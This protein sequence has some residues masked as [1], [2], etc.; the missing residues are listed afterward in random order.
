ME[1]STSAHPPA[2]PSHPSLLPSLSP[3]LSVEATPQPLHLLPLQHPHSQ[4]RMGPPQMSSQGV[5]GTIMG[6][7]P[8]HA[9]TQDMM[10]Q[11]KIYSAC[12]SGIPVFEA[13]IR[14]IA[15][16]RRG[17]D[18]WVNAT[19][20]LK[21]AGISKS[22]RTKILEKEVL[23]GIHE[24]VQGGYGKYQGTWV[25]YQRG[26][27]LAV[28]YGVLG[29]L[30]PIFDFDPSQAEYQSLPT[31][32]GM[33]TP[34]NRNMIA[35]PG[36]ARLISPF[37]SHA[38]PPPPPPQ[39]T[40]G[41]PMMGLPPHPSNLAYAQGQP[42]M[43]FQPQG[44]PQ[45]TYVQDRKR[46]MGM[47]M[48]PSRSGGSLVATPLAPGVDLDLNGMGLPPPHN[49]VYLDP[50]GH[51]HPLGDYVVNGSDGSGPPPAKKLRSNGPETAAGNGQGEA[52]DNVE[53]LLEA[54][55][56]DD[57]DDS[58]DELQDA[59]PLPTSM[60]LSTKPLRPK[61]TSQSSKTRTKLLSLFSSEE[62]VD[63]RS[64]FNLD[65]EAEAEFDIDMIID[66]QGHT[67]LHWACALAK[68]SIIQQLIALGADINRG[69]YAGETPL[70]R[71]VLA[72]N[73]SEA[74]TFSS[75]L[76]TGLASS[77]RTLDHAYRTVIHHIALIAGVPNR[78]SSARR[79]MT[80]IL[81]Y[82]ARK[83]QETSGNLS[84]KTLVDVQDVHGDTAL[85]VAARVGNR[86]LVNLLLEAGADKT[87]G[88]KLGLRPVDFGVETE[89]LKVSSGEEVIA[90]LKTETNRPEKQSRDVQKN[91]ATI[92]STISETF[93]NEMTVKQTALNKTQ[94]SVRHTTKALAEK[95]QQVASIQSALTELEQIKTKSENLTKALHA[96]SRIDF[97]GRTNST[98][99]AFQQS[100]FGIGNVAFSAEGGAE[101]AIPERGSES[102]LVNLRR[103]MMW[104]TRVGEM[105]E[106]TIQGL[107]GEGSEKEVRYRKLVA[108]CTKVPVDKVD[109]MLDDLTTAIESDG[110][111][112]DLSR[113]SNFMNRMKEV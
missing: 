11:S 6:I 66:D 8:G 24:K 57:D 20:I 35:P 37:T 75:L 65:A 12:Y 68:A 22:S 3:S 83:Q 85:N 54:E 93:D 29:F 4:S 46:P 39:F 100:A 84:M 9:P 78:A 55:E 60:R 28:Q 36:S 73:H 105:L 77:I 97:T 64:L 90:L 110:Q 40:N 26:H 21:V 112:I 67:A 104:E 30:A 51:P 102:A 14:G 79:Y 38:I 5:F 31:T 108:L 44:P 81:E 95:R 72:T 103:M 96:P 70:I 2:T 45:P 7:G 86:T 1:A 13:M 27:D 101:I 109:G 69:N 98:L 80:G 53:I 58:I 56:D 49:E 34:S 25:P 16:M 89:A 32:N 52:S 63:V 61:P 74:G 62:P 47:E 99:S 76:E 82:V 18:S 92:F 87:K 41:D 113:I 50:Y 111:S 43:Y 42:S 91:I 94:A 59:P 71:S 15:V 88:N 23:P 48:T 19:Q 106:N 33:S 107:E 17:A 10:Q